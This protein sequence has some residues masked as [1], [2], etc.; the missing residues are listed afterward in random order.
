VIPTKKSIGIFLLFSISAWCFLAYQYQYRNFKSD[1]LILIE[2]WAEDLSLA[3]IQ[4]NQPQLKA[5]IYKKLQLNKYFK[6]VLPGN[7]QELSGNQSGSDIF[8][9]PIKLYNIPAGR[10]AFIPNKMTIFIDTIKSVFFV[11]GLILLFLLTIMALYINSYLEFINQKKQLLEN[12][13]NFKK[14]LVR[15]IVHD[16]KS[17]LT[18]LRTLSESNIDSLSPNEYQKYLSLLETRFRDLISQLEIEDS[19]PIKAETL[20]TTQLEECLKQVSDQIALQTHN[21]VEFQFYT[22]ADHYAFCIAKG[23]LIRAFQNVLLNSCEANNEAGNKLAKVTTQL[24]E[25]ELFIQI[26]DQGKGFSGHHNSR[27]Q[28]TQ[29]PHRGIGLYSIQECLHLLKG[30]IEYKK[31]NV[32]GTMV[33]LRI[34][35]GS[36]TSS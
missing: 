31:Q 3:S 16:L 32:I 1:L 23:L 6:L 10:L 27:L 13:I 5:K 17:P 15:H 12:S 24:S 25:T 7:T 28:S 33:T 22:K 29:N 19:Q 4:K 36:S 20:S 8:F 21:I 26:C 11:S 34:P 2:T 9:V 30:S 14:Q 18:L 35:L